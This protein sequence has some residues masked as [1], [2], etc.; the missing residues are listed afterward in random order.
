MLS[1]IATE[2]PERVNAVTVSSPLGTLTALGA[3]VGSLPCAIHA[4]AKASNASRSLV[5][6]A[7]DGRPR[8]SRAMRSA[9]ARSARGESTTRTVG[10]TRGRYALVFGEHSAFTEC[11]TLVGGCCA[12]TQRSAR[13]RA[14][15]CTVLGAVFWRAGINRKSIGVFLWVAR[16][17]RIVRGPRSTQRSN[18]RWGNVTRR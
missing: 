14:H 12:H 6:S 5:A 13:Q 2:S 1:A 7:N 11:S 10:R 16:R 15:N 17:S 18:D 4:S 8:R 9:I 3:L